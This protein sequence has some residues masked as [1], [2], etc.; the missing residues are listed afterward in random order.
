MP[1]PAASCVDVVPHADGA[2]AIV[3]AGKQRP[4]HLNREG[5]RDMIEKLKAVEKQM[6]STPAVADPRQYT[7]PHTA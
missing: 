7:F 6:K 4:L 5:V 2:L 1:R 3:R